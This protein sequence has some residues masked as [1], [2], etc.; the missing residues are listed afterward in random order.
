MTGPRSRSYQESDWERHSNLSDTQAQGNK[1]CEVL[2]PSQGAFPN[3]LRSDWR[4]GD[5]TFSP[6]HLG[7]WKG[8]LPVSCASPLWFP[9]LSVPF[10]D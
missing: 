4:L 10:G 9:T 5:N 3:N 6:G 8:K 1:H 7:K 2:S